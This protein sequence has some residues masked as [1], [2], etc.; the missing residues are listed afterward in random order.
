MKIVSINKGPTEKSQTV[1]TLVPEDKEDLFTIYQIIDK[2]DEV[3]FKKLFTSKREDAKKNNTDLVTLKL[4]ILSN[5]FDMKDEYLRYKGVTVIDETGKANIDIALGKFLSFSIVYSHPLTIYKHH[6]NKYA[7]KLL[8]EA[9]E[10]ENKSDTA[11]VVLQEGIS[12]V[13]LLT[14]SSTI[15]K[16]KVQFTLPKKKSATDIVKFDDKV[17]SFYKATYEA[18]KL[19]LIHI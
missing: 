12:H 5:E 2:D 1:I 9:C 4:K 10:M 7:E 8:K 19:S 6:F 3:I 18:M 14:S 17:E 11:A 15:M 16:Q 13:C